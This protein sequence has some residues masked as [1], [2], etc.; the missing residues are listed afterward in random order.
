MADSDIS[1][2]VVGSGDTG[3]KKVDTRTVGALTDE[4][5]QVVVIGDPSTAAAVAGVD[6]AN[7]L[8][9]DVT[10]IA[11]G[12]N[13][14]GRMKL[15]DG[16]DVADVLDLTNS[17]PLTV[18]IVDSSGNQ[19]TSFGGS[20][21]TASDDDADFTAGTTPGTP[22][23]GVYESTPTAVTDGDMGIVGITTNRELNI[24]VAAS[25]LDVAHDAADSGNPVKI[26]TKAASALPAAVATDDRANA[27][28]DLFGRLLTSHIDPAMQVW[29]SLNYTSAQ[30]TPV[31]VWDPAAGK[32]IA[33]T[34]VVV[35]SYG[36]TQGR[37]LLYFDTTTGGYTAGTDQL[38]IGA[39][40]S[41]SSS[42][43]PGIV[44]TPPVP[45]VGTADYNLYVYTSAA[46]SI[47]IAIHGYEC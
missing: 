5:R 9:V 26:G 39:T 4:H 31:N 34:S 18:A 30:T 36:T 35:G 21:G 13:T 16:T 6:A 3:P 29:R 47:D 12:D 23:M 10:A 20:G 8:D 38:V 17:N 43:T 28:S 19:V 24:N 22:A 15:T 42:A 27:I 40:L 44:F 11:A 1:I 45:V 33:I 7:G 2:P 14:I 41:P 37:F 32:R 46:L 25:G